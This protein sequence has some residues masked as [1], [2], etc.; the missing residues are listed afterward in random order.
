MFNEAN[1]LP[2]FTKISMYPKLWESM[3]IDP[4]VLLDSL[5]KLAMENHA[6]WVKK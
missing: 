3:G 5:I 1:T 4:P 6:E 2:G